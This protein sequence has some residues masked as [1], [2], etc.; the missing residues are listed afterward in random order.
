[1]FWMT[2]FFSYLPFLQNY[3]NTQ[4]TQSG[5]RFLVKSRET[6]ISHKHSQWKCVSPPTGP[7]AEAFPSAASSSQSDPQP[8]KHRSSSPKTTS[9]P[10]AGKPGNH[11]ITHSAGGLFLF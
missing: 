8:E 11:S 6:S 10:S 7:S 4:A 9:C 3:L 2:A 1:M 5:C